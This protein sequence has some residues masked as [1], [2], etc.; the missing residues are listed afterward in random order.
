MRRGHRG[1]NKWYLEL[2]ESKLKGEREA[3]TEFARWLILSDKANKFWSSNGSTI[4]LLG[5]SESYLQEK[6]R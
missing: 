2:F 5:A 6:G 4:D 3:V 1:Y